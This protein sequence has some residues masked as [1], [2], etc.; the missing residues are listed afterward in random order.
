MVVIKLVNFYSNKFIN[1]LTLIIS[2]IIFFSI[3]YFINI[4]NKEN[5]AQ[6]PQIK[7]SQEEKIQ[8]KNPN[9][10]NIEKITNKDDNW[11]IQ[12]QSISLKAPIEESTNMNILEKYVGHFEETATSVGNIGLAGHNLGYKNNYFKNLNKIKKGDEILYKYKEFENVYVVNIIKTIKNTNWSYLESTEDNRITL[13]T[14]IDGKP[15]YR[16]CVQATEKRN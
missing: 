3:N 7:I 1:I 14:C 15:E 13:I 6:E 5:L 12:I 4:F 16:L 10:N 2:I 9:L 8:E 11:Y